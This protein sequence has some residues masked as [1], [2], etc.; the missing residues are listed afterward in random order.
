LN[1]ISIIT[2]GS[3]ISK[4]YIENN[5]GIYP[6][7]SSQTMNNGIIGKIDSYQVDGEYLT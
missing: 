3:V 2:R 5:K 1:E 6:V 7:Y 4:N